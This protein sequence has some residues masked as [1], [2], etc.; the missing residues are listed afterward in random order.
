MFILRPILALN[1]LLRSILSML[2]RAESSLVRTS[3]AVYMVKLESLSI[4]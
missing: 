1:L 3:S 2:I 4:L